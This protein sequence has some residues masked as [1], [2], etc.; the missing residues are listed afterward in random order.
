MQKIISTF[1]MLLSFL[2]NLTSQGENIKFKHITIDDGLSQNTIN[3]MLQDKQGFL[4]FGT[5]DG[6][7]KYDGYK[8]KIYKHDPDDSNSLSSS[9]IDFLYEDRYG[10][11]WITTAGGLNRFNPATETFFRYDSDPENPES[12]MSDKIGKLYEDRDGVLWVATAGGL[13]KYDRENDSFIR[14]FVNS[15]KPESGANTI[16][17]LCEDASGIFW[18]GTAEGLYLFNR[19]NENF[20]RYKSGTDKRG[21]LSGDYIFSVFEDRNGVLWF[22]TENGLFKFDKQNENFIR[23][24]TGIDSTGGFSA[25]TVRSIYEDKSGYLWLRSRQGVYRFDK[26]RERFEYFYH[27]PDDPNSLSSGAVNHVFEDK[28][29]TIWIGTWGG[30][31]NKFVPGDRNGQK[32]SFVRYRYNPNNPY[33]LSND[34]IGDILED[35]SGVIW[36]GTF[37]GGLNKFDAGSIKF[38]HFKEIPNSDNCLRGKVVWSILEDKTGILWIG[39]EGGGLNKF[40]RSTNTYT[41]YLHD[42]FDFTSL[43]H[44]TVMSL[45]EDRSGVLW[46][47]T[48]GGGLNRLVPGETKNAPPIFAKYQFNPADSTTIGGNA[49]VS[50]C[51]DREGVLWTGTFGGGL[52]KIIQDSSKKFIRYRNNPVDENSI[53]HNVVV[54]IFEDSSGDLWIGTFGGGLNKYDR[55]N[56]SFIRYQNVPGDTTSLSNDR[57]LSIHES[58]INPDI[59]WIGTMGGGLN[60]FDKRSETFRYFREKH[61]L[62]ND[63][64]YGILE[65]NSGD[66]WLS[67]NRGIAEFNQKTFEVKKYD[68]SDGLQSN[69]FSQFAYY[70]SRDGEMFFGGINGFNSFFPDSVKNNQCIPPVVITDFKLFNESVPV[71]EMSDGRTILNKSISATDEI[72]L[73]HKDNTFTIEFAAL[74]YASSDKNNYAYKLDGFDKGWYYVG[75]RRFASYTGLSPGNYTFRVKASNNDGVWNEEGTSVGIIIKPPMW[76]TWWFRITAVF[77]IAVLCIAGYRIRTKYLF[78]QTRIETELQAAH[79]AQMSIMPQEDPV[80]DGFD[81]SGTCIPAS[82]VGGDFFDYL[83]LDKDKTRFGIVIGDVSGKAMKAAMTAVMTSG[84]IYLKAGEAKSIREIVSRVNRSLYSKIDRTMFTALCLASF[85]S[86]SHELNFTNAGLN[87]PLLITKGSAEYLEGNGPKFPLGIKENTRYKE[88]KVSVNTGDVVIFFSDGIPEA[89]NP[90]KEFYGYDRLKKLAENLDTASLTALEIKKKIIED[91]RIF[92][93]KAHQ[94]DDMAVVVIKLL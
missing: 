28:N 38:D 24:D 23:Y 94:Y 89:Q 66:L 11:L 36:I 42:P 8:I 77:V 44:N 45:Y 78:Q 91:V 75:T 61:G 51:E 63:V 19:T 37:T 25:Y 33:G 71:G 26:A 85:D 46:I 14:Y 90:E 2:V 21:N 50:L 83:W 15:D 62:P 17:S 55:D 3:S 48:N 64:I 74:N 68:E 16:L 32:H 59:L 93:R 40:D 6:L 57:V 67:T 27:N 52:S 60:R 58:L 82:E 39:T 5:Q 43:S 81:I 22:G 41:H 72:D 53:S 56:D 76:G 80:I 10:D 9:T 87:E 79:D 88:Q 35:R 92:S 31:I 65:D 84:M 18:V 30:G 4:W 86:A 29:G 12:T 54:S 47:G 13:N 69:E 20:I 1:L 34:Q 73:T 49:V 70:K 7:N